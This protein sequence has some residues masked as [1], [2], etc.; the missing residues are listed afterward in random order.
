MPFLKDDEVLQR[1]FA[2]LV[3]RIQELHP[4]R[5]EAPFTV[6]EIYQNL[7]PY[8]THREEIGVAL[9]ADYEHALLRLLG[10]E[11]E[12]LILDSPPARAEIR[13]E[14]ESPDPNTGLYREFAAA[15]VRLNPE[16]VRELSD[17]SGR[18]A[19][20]G[21]PE[22]SVSRE[23]VWDSEGSPDVV[24]S[25]LEKGVPRL[26]DSQRAREEL[27]AGL[28]SPGGEGGVFGGEGGRIGEP[29]EATV[30]RGKRKGGTV[31]AENL[32]G[33]SPAPE[34]CPWCRENLPK[35]PGVRF[36]PYCGSNVRLIPCPE[37]GEELELNWRF[38][39]ACGTEVTS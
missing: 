38:C 39:I 21:S 11:G 4:D 31:P 17:R 2:S 33:L 27:F 24:R 36:C 10:G 35:R 12:Y 23:A 6:A 30:P 3:R 8:R 5:L 19:G 34:A 16:K 14:L 20:H 13:R 25:G 15:D 37:C 28:S 26:L 18:E 22:T 32:Q 29:A 1:F 7:V 9:S